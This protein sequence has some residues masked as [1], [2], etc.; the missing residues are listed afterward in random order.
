MTPVSE[1]FFGDA[2]P[3]DQIQDTDAFLNYLDLPQEMQVEC[4]SSNTFA[5]SFS[6]V[7]GQDTPS[8]LN[9][10]QPNL[11]LVSAPKPSL[12]LSTTDIH[13]SSS[14]QRTLM[15]RGAHSRCPLT[16][17]VLGQIM[18]YP[19]LLIE[20][21]QLPP[22]IH[23]GCYIDE[24]LAHDCMDSDAHVCLPKRIAACA[25][26]VRI[27]YDRRN[28]ESDF[29]WDVIRREAD[30]IHGQV[31]LSLLTTGW[32]PPSYATQPTDLL[33]K[34]QDGLIT[35]AAD[36]LAALQSLTI[37]L[38]LQ[39]EVPGS[40]SE[41]GAGGMIEAIMVS[42]LRLYSHHCLAEED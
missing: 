39:A 18:S 29:V 31:C 6:E 28:R 23:P 26:L 13:S 37:L 8:W 7:Y 14:S 12:T 22:F 15:R 38:L 30:E 4:A 20:G 3:Y 35:G 32:Q 16:S 11:P 33:H 21:D 25:T 42:T 24:E 5:V 17:M 41:H 34:V 9:S 10:S 2:V 19:R 27:F 40:A 36:Q 1:G